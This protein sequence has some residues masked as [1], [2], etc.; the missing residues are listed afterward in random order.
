MSSILS[1]NNSSIIGVFDSG[2]GGLTIL[3]QLKLDYPDN[4]FIYFGDTA[5][6]PYG[7][8]S[9]DSIIK[10]SD[11]IVQFLVSKGA[12]IIVIACHTA[13]SVAL[14]YLRT[15]Y[16]IPILGVVESSINS[17]INTT[18]SNHISVL[19]T[20]TTITSHSYRNK[21]SQISNIIKV[22]EIECPLFVPIVE[23]GLENSDISLLVTK[24]Y[25]EDINHTKSDTIILGCTHYPILISTIQKIINSRIH[26][27][28]T[29]LSVSKE[30]S[31]IVS[32]SIKC[33][34]DDIYYVTDKP[35]RFNTLA[36]KFL[37]YN[38]NQINHVQ[39]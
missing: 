11:Q 32:C 9:E 26:I 10:F 15:K 34:L 2:L 5:H 14:N 6:L 23:E 18:Q 1:N 17:A 7:T 36:S 38:I 30:L 21:I 20:H 3:N 35:Y 33:N 22:D 19:G 13:S 39:L 8:K 28:D 4:Q 29:G 12:N 31:Q 24:L 37:K 16:D 27:I 25:L